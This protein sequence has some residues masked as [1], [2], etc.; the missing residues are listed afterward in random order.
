MSAAKSNTVKQSE[1]AVRMILQENL[2]KLRNEKKLTQKQVAEALNIS[3]NAYASYETRTV[4]P[5]FLIVL[6]SKM[7]AVSPSVF[8]EKDLNTKL[9]FAQN[10]DNVYGESKFADLSDREKLLLLKYRQ[11]NTKDKNEV[12]EMI[13][14]KLEQI[15][16][17]LSIDE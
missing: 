11:L 17:A 1:D 6:L 9:I 10:N 4:P 15:T 14:Q 5:H 7:Y 12:N 8:Y 13:S 2:I 3:R 16:L